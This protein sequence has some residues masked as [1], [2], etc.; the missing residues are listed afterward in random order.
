MRRVPL[1][2]EIL[3]P[4]A[5]GVEEEERVRRGF[6]PTLRKAMRQIPFSEDVVAA[7]YCAIDPAVPWRVRATLLGALAYFVAPVDAV[8]D[9]LLGIGFSDDATVLVGAITMVAAHITEEHR[10]RA[11]D[12]LAD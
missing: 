8:P 9:V 10:K 7:Y 1:D 5:V 6:W 4:E 3:G 12:A 11:R 2:G